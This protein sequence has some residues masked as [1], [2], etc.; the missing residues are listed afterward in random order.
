LARGC[1]GRPGTFKPENR[2]SRINEC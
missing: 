2:I 1:R